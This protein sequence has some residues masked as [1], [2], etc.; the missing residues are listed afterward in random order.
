MSRS[1]IEKMIDDAC[2][3]S[4]KQEPRQIVLYC[5]GCLLRKS[6][7]RHEN[8]PPNAV[9]AHIQCPE[10]VGGDFDTTYYYDVN[11]N[12]IPYESTDQTEQKS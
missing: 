2:G 3:V 11:G 8:D 7:D 12:E 5:S 9:L 10:C 6:V 4:P 1:P